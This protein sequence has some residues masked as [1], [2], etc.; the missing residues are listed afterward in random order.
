MEPKNDKGTADSFPS[1]PSNDLDDENPYNKNIENNNI[2]AKSDTI[3]LDPQRDNISDQLG[4]EF[5]YPTETKV[6]GKKDKIVDNPNMKYELPKPNDD[7]SSNENRNFLDNFDKPVDLNQLPNNNNNNINNNFGNNNVIYPNLSNCG[8]NNNNY[9]NLS[10]CGNNN[11]NYNN[12]NQNNYNNNYGRP[13]NY[14]NNYNNNNYNNNF[15]NNNNNNFN[16]NNN[17]N[18]NN[19]ENIKKIQNI[20]NTCDAKYKNAIAQF[21]NYQIIESKKTLAYLINSLTNVERNVREKNQFASSLLPNISSLKNN[22]SNKLYE[23]NYFTYLL[24]ANLFKNVQY[25]KNTDIAKYAEKFILNRS[26]VTF[27]DIYDTS[28]DQNNPT[29]NVLLEI[30]GRAQKSGY[31]TLFLY[32]PNGSG[33]TLYVH[34]LAAELGAILGQLDNLQNIKIQ[35]FVKEFARII[36]E[37]INRPII[38]YIKN[39]DSLCKNALGEILFLHDKF[40]T[41]KKNALFICSSPFPIKNLP[42]QLKF[43]YIH[44]INSAN[45]TQKYNLFRFL[46]NKFGIKFSMTD[47]ELSNFVYQNFRNY[48]NQ[49]VFQVIKTAMDLKKNVGGSIFEMGRNE[50]ENALKVKPGSLDPQCMQYYGL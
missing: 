38:I 31:K 11:N 5:E 23:C 32:G 43:K 39:V 48:S 47:S 22:I 35:Y 15:N 7:N 37:Y 21:K 50:L 26:F 20:I 4:L 45:Q 6:F 27:N 36:T 42:Q 9:P 14:N 1:I 29:K 34:A 46:T 8:N 30:Y 28:L 16:N 49:D 41:F 33:K 3:Q 12:F 40:N 19:N 17:N 24:N 2:F 25:Q 18:N 10:N 44:L 13:N